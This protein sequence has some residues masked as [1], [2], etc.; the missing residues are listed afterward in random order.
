MIFDT[1]SNIAKYPV[2]QNIK[3]AL[4]H[5]AKNDFNKLEAGKYHLDGDNIF[6]MVQDYK[7]APISEKRLEFH[8]KYIDIQLIT[9]GLEKIAFCSTE[10]LSLDGEFND[11]SDIGFFANNTKDKIEVAGGSAILEAGNFMIL[12][13]QDAHAPGIS[14]AGSGDVRKVVYKVLADE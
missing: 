1:I 9:K 12:F 5:I 4:E 14:V 3:R 6:Y 7:T 10:G 11:E 8:K 2:S 13:P